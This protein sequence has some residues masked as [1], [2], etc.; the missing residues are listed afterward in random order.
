MTNKAKPA[1][2]YWVVSVLALLWNLMGVLAYLGQAFITEEMKAEYSPEQ[3]ALIE[4]RPSWVTAAFA[5]AVWGGLLG[6][7]ALLIRKRWARPLLL[8][9]LLGV[10]AQTSYNLFATNAAEVFGQLQGLVI[11]LFVVV[12]ALILVLIAKIADRKQW[13]S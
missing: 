13:L 7:I 4:G 5:I 3:L 1:T 11:P 9:S 2:W 10:V 6:C 8:I 12:I